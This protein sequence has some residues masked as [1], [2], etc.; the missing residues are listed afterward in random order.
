MIELI[1]IGVIAGLIAKSLSNSDA[2]P[3]RSADQS[4]SG[5]YGFDHRFVDGNWRAYI[6]RQPGYRG[7]SEDLHDTHRY[8]DG[9]EHYVCW[10]EPVRTREESVAIANKWKKKTDVCIRNGTRF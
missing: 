8:R 7:R 3:S 1:V 10:S 2:S 4:S 9:R 6:V 5:D